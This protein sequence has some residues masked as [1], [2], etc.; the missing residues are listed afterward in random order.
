LRQVQVKTLIS[1]DQ[2]EINLRFLRE[3]ASKFG[4]CLIMNNFYYLFQDCILL[5]DG[6]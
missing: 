4:L 3:S 6:L 1:A 2:K 5:K